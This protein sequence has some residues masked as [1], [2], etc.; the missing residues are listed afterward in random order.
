MVK[1]SQNTQKTNQTIGDLPEG[2]DISPV[3]TNTRHLPLRTQIPDFLPDL[4][5]QVDNVEDCN[6]S[7]KPNYH[8]FLDN[9]FRIIFF[10]DQETNLNLSGILKRNVLDNP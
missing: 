6:N 3:L 2:H 7:R 5:T 10:P 8:H 4:T 1:N 9:F